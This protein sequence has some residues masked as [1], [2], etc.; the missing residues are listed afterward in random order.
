M[1]ARKKDNLTEYIPINVC[2]A[3]I[4]VFYFR[5]F[6]EVIILDNLLD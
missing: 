5:T 2:L 6:L 4:D 1:H 3:A